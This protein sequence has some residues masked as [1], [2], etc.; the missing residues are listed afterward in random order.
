MSIVLDADGGKVERL[1]FAPDDSFAIETIQDVEPTIEANKR[2]RS[3]NPSGMGA[4]REWQHVASI[5]PV[6]QMIWF[7]KYGIK[8]W[9]HDHWPAVLRLLNSSEWSLLRTNEGQI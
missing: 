9:D 3:D 4:S 1:H 6:V 8:A 2:L 7:E 5:P